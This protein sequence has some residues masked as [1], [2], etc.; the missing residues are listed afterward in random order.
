MVLAGDA[1]TV[2]YGPTVALRD[3]SLQ[4]DRGAV[5]GV[6]GGNGAG[7]STLGKALAGLARVSAG[8]ITVDG[9][10]VTDLPP[11]SRARLGVVLVPQTRAIFPNLTVEEN[12]RVPLSTRRGSETE[13]DVL[14]RIY[15]HYPELAERRRARAGVLSGGE[16]QMIAVARALAMEPRYLICDEPS[17][18][19]APQYVEGTFQRL[20]D[21]VDTEK[22][23]CVLIE[24]N[25]AESV[26]WCESTL[27]LERGA[28]IHA[29]HADADLVGE[30]MYGS[31]DSAAAD[32]SEA[33]RA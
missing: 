10:E 24:Q 30:I 7:K 16:R 3:V 32:A 25:V 8:E 28:V 31:K 26:Q 1:V 11:W 13:G 4:V 6:Y 15:E 22:L 20:R 12:L 29:G 9:Q 17:A 33:G 18:G 21:L 2:R 19:L 27:V 23:G 14:S 5:L